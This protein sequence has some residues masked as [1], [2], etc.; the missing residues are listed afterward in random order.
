MGLDHPAWAG[1]ARRLRWD[2]AVTQGKPLRK[3]G[4]P[5]VKVPIKLPAVTTGSFE[6]ADGSVAAFIVNATPEPQR[7]VVHLPEAAA[8]TVYR[9]D[10]TEERRHGGHGK[11]ELLLEPFGVRVLV[12]TKR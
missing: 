5:V 9:A 8:T 2:G 7:A 12:M 6:A 3:G 10:Q 4:P 1:E 11:L